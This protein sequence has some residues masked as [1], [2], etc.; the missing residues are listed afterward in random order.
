MYDMFNRKVSNLQNYEKA[1]L[2]YEAQPI[3]TGRI[4]FY[5]SSAFT[6]WKEKF[7][8]RPL[9]EDIRMKDGSPAAVNHGFGGGI[10][11]QGLYYYDRMVKPWAP[12]AIVLRF[13]PNDIAIGYSPMEI[14]YL[15]SL[16]CNRARADLPGVKFYLC[17]AMP[18]KKFMDNL[19]WKKCAK[20]Y[21]QLLDNYCEL[22]EDCTYV[23]Q[24]T[25][26]GF[27]ENPEDAGDYGKV[28]T[29]IWAE[30]EMHFTQEGYN[31]YRDLFLNALDD[32]L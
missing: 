9:E 4:L 13:F 32:I 6:R 26:P 17:D 1:I 2:V 31:I 28:R 18:H 15:I 25:W 23:S 30:D 29:D 27:Y 20:Q 5:G 8:V 16:F 22:N 19:A 21:N 7:G 12:R 10:M 11:E 24:S 3:E 14:M